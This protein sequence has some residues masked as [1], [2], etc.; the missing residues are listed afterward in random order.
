MKKM[1]KVESAVKALKAAK[2]VSTEE[3][4]IDVGIENV[5]KVSDEQIQKYCV[6]HLSKAN[7]RSGSSLARAARDL[8]NDAYAEYPEQ[9]E[10]AVQYVRAALES[11]GKSKKY[12]QNVVGYG[13]RMLTNIAQ[14]KAPR[15]I[16]KII[17]EHARVA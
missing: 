16:T 12:V 10:L 13:I 8:I 4:V 2:A 1:M 14:N 7:S 17:R 3:M 9:P 15:Y 6:K 5:I 11:E